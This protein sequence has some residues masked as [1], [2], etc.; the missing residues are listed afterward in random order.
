[1]ALRLFSK[2]IS[3]LNFW[4]DD[5]FIVITLVVGIPSSVM[6]VHGLTANGLGRDIWTVSF[7]QITDFLHIFYAMEILYFAEVALLKLSLLFFYLRIF[8]GTKIRRLLWATIAFDIMFGIAFVFTG[9]FQCQPINYYWQQ[10]DGEHQGKCFNLN[11]LGW[12]N[13]AISITLDL[14]MIGLPMS[15]LA[16]IKLHWKKKIGVALMFIVGTL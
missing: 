5:W 2:F 15:Q 14:W 7:Q 9:I 3:G 13:A 10:W 11:A 8:P 16:H 4:L 1:M 12:A 6:T